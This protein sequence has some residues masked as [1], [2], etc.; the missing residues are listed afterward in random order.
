MPWSAYSPMRSIP[1][2]E[3]PVIRELV[4]SYD[5]SDSSATYAAGTVTSTAT[6]AIALACF[7]VNLDE[8]SKYLWPTLEL[9]ANQPL[10]ALPPSSY[11]FILVG[12]K[13]LSPTTSRS[14]G[15]NVSAA[16]RAM[17][18][19]RARQIPMVEIMLN[20][21][22]DMAPNPMMTEAPEM[23]MDS[24]AHLMALWSAAWW[25]LPSRLSSL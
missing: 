11:S 7:S 1:F 9:Q 23:V 19:P 22:I 13:I 5:V 25:S 24:P 12:Q 8:M 17:T 18:M 10:V 3:S 4:M 15:M 20:E 2:S 21:Q 6:M 14:E 16:S